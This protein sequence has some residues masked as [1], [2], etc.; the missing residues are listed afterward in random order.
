MISNAELEKMRKETGVALFEFSSLH[1]PSG[2]WKS[3]KNLI[4]DKHLPADIRNRRLENKKDEWPPPH[5]I[6]KFGDRN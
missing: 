1:L 2:I 6:M 3:H 5:L 4:K